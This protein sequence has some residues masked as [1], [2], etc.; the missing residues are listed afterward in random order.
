MCKTLY[1]GEHIIWTGSIAFGKIRAGLHGSGGPKIGEV[2]C[3]GSA[4]LSCKRDQSKMRE[5]M[6]RQV[7]TPMR[8]TSPT[9]CPPLL[10]KQALKNIYAQPTYLPKK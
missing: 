4:D 2:T 5:H 6:G 1:G 10:C 7:T 8:D 3:V 9:S